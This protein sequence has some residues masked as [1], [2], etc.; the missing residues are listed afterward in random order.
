MLAV[1]NDNKLGSHV[2][3]VSAP[4]KP[5]HIDVPAH[6]TVQFKDR[7][8]YVPNFHKQAPLAYNPGEK[9]GPNNSYTNNLR[10]TTTTNP[11]TTKES[12]I[13]GWFRL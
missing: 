5:L 7:H 8:D 2:V 13:H 3:R 11:P 9:S 1:V 10:K 4:V 6:Q 12:P